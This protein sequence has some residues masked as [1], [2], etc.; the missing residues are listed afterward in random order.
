MSSSPSLST[1]DLRSGA[2]DY[3]RDK[4]HAVKWAL[5]ESEFGPGGRTPI[6]EGARR[7]MQLKTTVSRDGTRDA[8]HAMRKQAHQLRLAQRHEL[9]DEQSASDASDPSE[10]DSARGPAPDADITYSYDAPAGPGGRGSQI[11]GLA[12]AKAVEKFETKETD[13]LIKE[14]YEVV[15]ED[16]EK[17]KPVEADDFELV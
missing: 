17:A 1:Q 5:G 16:G 3:K 10:E 6:A 7:P 8:V 15:V 13:R 12:L 2:V 11:L 4:T 14:E 9:D